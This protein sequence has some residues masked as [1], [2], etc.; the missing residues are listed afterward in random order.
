MTR[1]DAGRAQEGERI[2]VWGASGSGKSAWTKR[3]LAGLG[4]VAV[5]DP[6][7]EYRRDGFARFDLAS[8]AKMERHILAHWRDFRVCFVPPAGAEPDA[9]SALAWYLVGVQDAAADQGKAFPKITLV[10]EELNLA[11]PT[12]GANKCRGFAEVCSR[13]R[14]R[15][16]EVIGV[17]QRVAEVAGRFRDN[18]TEHVVF[19]QADEVGA[20]RAA[21]NARLDWRAVMDLPRLEY[22]HASPAGTARKKVELSRKSLT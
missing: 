9:L 2:G 7:D 1:A 10:A 21:A 5:F 4:R 22:F 8:V 11:F 3:R 19:R 13:G 16:I 17:S 15:H 20:R 18:L 12:H 14:A 6:Q